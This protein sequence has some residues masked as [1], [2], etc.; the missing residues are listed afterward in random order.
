MGKR[1]RQ[2]WP[3]VL[4]SLLDTLDHCAIGDRVEVRFLREDQVQQVVVVLE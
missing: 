2:A 4:E 1:T 3:S